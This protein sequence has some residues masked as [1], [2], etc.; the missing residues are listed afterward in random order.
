M[1]HMI[2]HQ[3][4]FLGM[5]MVTN[6]D[7]TTHPW[8]TVVHSVTHEKPSTMRP[9]I[10]MRPLERRAGFQEFGSFTISRQSS[11]LGHAPLGPGPLLLLPIL[12][13]L[14][15]INSQDPQA[16]AAPTSQQQPLLSLSFTFFAFLFSTSYFPRTGRGRVPS[17]EG[18]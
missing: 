5:K 12:V 16:T 2:C 18:L 3:Q 11:Q 9:T 8:V 17:I 7:L 4:A 15:C 6:T 1:K 13:W 10:R 14:H